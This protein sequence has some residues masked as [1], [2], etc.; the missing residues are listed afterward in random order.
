MIL[1]KFA[2]ILRLRLKFVFLYVKICND[3][4]ESYEFARIGTNVPGKH[5]G[6]T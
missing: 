1:T 5:F 2:K 4:G 6:F 3:K